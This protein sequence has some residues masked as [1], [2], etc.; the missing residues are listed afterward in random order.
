MPTT[1]NKGNYCPR[2]FAQQLTGDSRTII[3]FVDSCGHRW[4]ALLY[5]ST[6][7]D[8]SES[9]VSSLSVAAIFMDVAAAAKD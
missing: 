6:R 1:I 9:L 5:L 7:L 4:W 3:T 2:V 8:P